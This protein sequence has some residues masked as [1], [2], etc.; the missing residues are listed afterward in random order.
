[1]NTVLEKYLGNDKENKTAHNFPKLTTLGISTP[2]AP[3]I[4]ATSMVEASN[5]SQNFDY[6]SALN[7]I[8]SME[9]IFKFAFR[10]REL[11]SQCHR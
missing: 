6:E 11:L 1:M 3:S 5:N 2:S 8:K 9:Y 4:E 10:S 7:T